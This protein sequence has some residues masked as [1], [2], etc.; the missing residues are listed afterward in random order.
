MHIPI[1][2]QHKNVPTLVNLFKKYGAEEIGVIMR[3]VF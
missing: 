3:K 1:T 2:S